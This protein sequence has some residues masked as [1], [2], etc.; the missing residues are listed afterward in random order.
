[1]WKAG[2]EG[3]RMGKVIGKQGM[4]DKIEEGTGIRGNKRE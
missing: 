1:M 4:E 3:N 2:T